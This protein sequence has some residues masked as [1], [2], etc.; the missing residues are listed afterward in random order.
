MNEFNLVES[1]AQSGTY[2]SN[3]SLQSFI[4]G[5]FGVAFRA[6][7]LGFL[8]FDAMFRHMFGAFLWIRE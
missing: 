1:G 4:I 7:Q 5:I 8:L 6:S 2:F 3:M